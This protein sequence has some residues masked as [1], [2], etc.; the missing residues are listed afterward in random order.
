MTAAAVRSAIVT[1]AMIDDRR[2][3]LKMIVI[4]STAKKHLLHLNELQTCVYALKMS[5][6]RY[7]EYGQL[8]TL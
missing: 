4:V 2:F 6:K 3:E 5:K 8:P 7:Y 1:F